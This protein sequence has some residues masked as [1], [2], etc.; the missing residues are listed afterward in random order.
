MTFDGLY[1][2][3]GPKDM[4]VY[5][6]FETKSVPILQGQ[7]TNTV[8]VLNA[9]SAYV[10]KTKG[11]QTVEFWHQ[12]LG[13][14]GFDKL[15]RIIEKGLV[16]G[17]PKA[18]VKIDMVC[19]GCQFGKAA[20]LPFTSSDHRSNSPLELV[21]SDV[22]GPIKQS[23]MSGMK[24]MVTFIDDFSRFVWLY[25]MKEKTE[26]FSKF[27]I[28]EIEAETITKSKVGCLRSDNG[29]EYIATDFDDY[30]KQKRIRRQFTC[31]NTPQQNGV[32]E[33]KNRHLGEV[34]RSLI[35][36]KNMPGRFWAEAM[37]TAGYLINRIPAQGLEYVSPYEKITGTKPDV[38]YLKVFGCVCYVFVPGHLRHKMEK[39]AIRCVFVGYDKERKGWRCCNPNTGKIYVSRNVIFDENSSWWSSSNE[40]L[41]DTQELLSDLETSKINLQFDGD[42]TTSDTIEVVQ[43]ANE[44]EGDISSCPRRSQRVRRPNPRYANTTAHV[45]I[46]E[47]AWAEP[48]SFEEACEKENGGWP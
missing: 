2:M 27:K 32:S 4:K 14:V 6:N 7:K 37:Y 22:F 46:V 1:V 45:A 26:V 3:F 23:S 19:S 10:E 48:N 24:Y 44:E 18:D 42:D 25:F 43:Q 20:Q 38:S 41:P 31:P 21:H 30:L 9:E 34:T 35:H 29:G 47:D 40:V 33:R 15:G 17:L 13:H 11:K 36:D 39:K 8:Y 16:H 12:R 28:F 5:K